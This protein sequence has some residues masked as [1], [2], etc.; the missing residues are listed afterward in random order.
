MI[1]IQTVLLFPSN[2]L[3]VT[4][5]SAAHVTTFTCFSKNTSREILSTLFTF[6]TNSLSKFLTGFDELEACRWNIYQERGFSCLF[7]LF[8]LVFVVFWL[9]NN[10]TWSKRP[11]K[12]IFYK[13]TTKYSR[14]TF[15]H[16]FSKAFT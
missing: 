16:S 9:N 1:Q 14:K 12:L 11:Q 3:Q 13:K 8:F 10:I 6:S 15:N 5:H 2:K 7:S 4:L